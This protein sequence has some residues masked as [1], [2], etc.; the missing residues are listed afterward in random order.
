LGNDVAREILVI[1]AVSYNDGSTLA[2]IVESR[3]DHP[4]KA[5]VS[6]FDLV[7]IVPIFEIQPII[8]NN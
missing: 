3:H 1:Q 4:V 8:E 5:L 7:Q 2:W 6:T